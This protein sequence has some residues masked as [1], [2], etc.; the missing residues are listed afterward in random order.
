MWTEFTDTPVYSFT[1]SNTEAFYLSKNQPTT[2]GYS[3]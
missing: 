2:L 1:S 3:W